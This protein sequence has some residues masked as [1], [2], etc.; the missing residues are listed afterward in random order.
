[1]TSYTVVTSL[2]F[3]H[4]KP[5]TF[6][7]WIGDSENSDAGA[8]GMGGCA[9]IVHPLSNCFCLPLLPPSGPKKP[10]LHFVFHCALPNVVKSQGIK[11]N[12]VRLSFESPETMVF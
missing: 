1:M 6:V 3:L 10:V 9:W 11:F 5:G 4:G 2:C 12:L 8:V 7:K